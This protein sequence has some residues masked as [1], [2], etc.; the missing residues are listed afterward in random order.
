[1]K[2]YEEA[3]EKTHWDIKVFMGKSSIWNLKKTD[4]GLSIL[5]DTPLSELQ[6]EFKTKTKRNYAEEILWFML[7]FVGMSVNKLR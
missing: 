2:V 1:M 6:T 5:L 7:I 3:Y 4:S